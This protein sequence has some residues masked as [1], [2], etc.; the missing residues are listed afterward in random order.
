MVK[1]KKKGS[2]AERDLLQLFWENNW[3]CLR[4]AGSGNTSFPAPDLLASNGR[5]Q[6]ALECKTF[7]R[8]CKYLELQEISQ[9]R[10]FSQ[11][12]GAEAWIAIKFDYKPW[13][14]LKIDDLKKTEKSCVVSLKLAQ[15]KGFLLDNFL[16][17]N[18][19][20]HN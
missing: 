19:K 16:T 8:E 4:V 12:F 13:Y 17:R 6:V 14:F 20:N 5:R 10:A 18:P 1:R 15:E 9:L 11:M 7:K 2:Q 3:A